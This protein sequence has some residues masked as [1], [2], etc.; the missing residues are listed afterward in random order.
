M[1]QWINIDLDKYQRTRQLTQELMEYTGGRTDW[2]EQAKMA[3]P[4]AKRSLVSSTFLG[5]F[6]CFQKS[7]K[8]K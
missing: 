8:K 4:Q 2:E 5:G 1:S 6:I 3:E 7:N